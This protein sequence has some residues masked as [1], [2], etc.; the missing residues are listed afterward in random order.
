MIMPGLTDWASF[1]VCSVQDQQGSSY[2][3]KQVKTH[4]SKLKPIDPQVKI[5]SLWTWKYCD[6][7]SPPF[8]GV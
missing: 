2:F 1:Q 5:V 4:I 8:A 6:A 7:S 3:A